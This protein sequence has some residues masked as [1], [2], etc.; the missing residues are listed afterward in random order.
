MKRLDRILL[1]KELRMLQR[2]NVIAAD[3]N[4]DL[5]ART[6]GTIS[7]HDQ[8]RLSHRD[9]LLSIKTREHSKKISFYL[10][11]IEVIT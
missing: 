3:I 5:K 7:V 1:P 8:V 11:V 6:S 9:A 10:L 4:K 2:I